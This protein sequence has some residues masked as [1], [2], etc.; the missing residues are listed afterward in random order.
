MMPKLKLFLQSKPVFLYLLPVFFVLHGFTENYPSVPVFD[1]IKL[2]I[3]YLLVTLL[4]AFS[5]YFIFRSWQNA[6]IFAFFLMCLQFFFVPF[7]DFLKKISP[8]WFLSKYSVL[9][10]LIFLIVLIFFLFFRKTNRQFK[11]AMKYF[12]FTL[13]LL[14]II[15]SSILIVKIFSHS[16]ANET[17]EGFIT[18]NDCK[19]P[20]IYLII[21]DE[22]AGHEELRDI[23]S[24]DNSAFENE[25]RK[26]NFFV[27]KK[28]LSNYNYTPYSMGSIL[29]MKYLKG[30]TDKS[31]DIR[32]RNICYENI[33][34]N[35]L[36]T[37]FKKFGYDFVNL[38]LFD[39]ADKPTSINSYE[40]YS[41]RAKL[42][43]SQTFTGRLKKD[44]WYHLITTFKFRWAQKNLHDK[45]IKNIQK[46]YDAT[47][48]AAEDSLGQP[49]FIYTHFNMPHYPYLFDKQGNELSFKESAQEGRKDLYLQYLQYC[50]KKCLFLI[51]FILKKDM[52]KPII[53]LM[54]DHGF[55]KYGPAID[56]SYNFK[57][58]INIYFPD[59]DYAELPD[60]ISN[61]NLFRIILNTQFK[62][63]LPLLKD[64]TI[65]LKEY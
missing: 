8:H 63:K 57:N 53:I 22:Y 15:D 29:S 41:T 32:N 13:G 35:D 56:P 65:F 33:N 18:C 44:L 38:S 19:K 20:N 24:F 47:L 23:F 52:T 17:F 58:V 30:I 46:Q 26:R 7:H 4:L 3:E 34:K 36:T 60:S 37:I 40:F 11:T 61:V 31:N 14:I 50:N 64:S 16:P 12:T 21:T 25:L 51:D 54:S 9:L 28:S 10:P 62:Q 43:S 27:V 48:A 55:T 45:F 5:F 1:A 2:T 42:I 6:V 49:R 39:F 59:K